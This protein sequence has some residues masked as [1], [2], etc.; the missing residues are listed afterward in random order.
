MEARAAS[1]SS[2]REGLVWVWTCALA[3]A[4]LLAAG[5]RDEAGADAPSPAARTSAER[6]SPGAKISAAFAARMTRVRAE[7]R[8]SAAL[9]ERPCQPEVI[10]RRVGRAS[11]EM[12][13]IEEPELARFDAPRGSGQ[14]SAH[15]RWKLLTNERLAT[16]AAAPSSRD[17]AT[18][19]AYAIRELEREHPFLGVLRITERRLP[20]PGAGDAGFVAGKIEGWLIVYDLVTAERLCQTTFF[21]RSSEGVAFNEGVS[22]DEGLWRDLALGLRRAL[23]DAAHR[24]SRQLTLSLD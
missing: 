15:P 9:E 3:A 13:V 8:G 23:D 7:L 14:A 12:V 22:P 11:T 20:A 6:S 5:C 18:S 21:A 2:L 10:E 19:L 17:E 1:R 4:A 16:L 24:L